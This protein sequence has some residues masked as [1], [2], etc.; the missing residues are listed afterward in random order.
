MPAVG[1]ATRRPLPSVGSPQAGFPYPQ[2]YYGALRRPATVPP[3]FVAFAW[4]YHPVRLCSSLRAGPT[5]AWGQEL[6]VRQLPRRTVARWSPQGLPGSQATLMHLCPVLRP[7]QDRT[8]LAHTACRHG[9]RSDNAEGSPRVMLSGLNSTALVLAV[10]ASPSP[11][12]CRRRK[13]RFR[14]LARPCRVGLATHRVAT[15]GFKDT[16]PSP[17]FLSLA[18]RNVKSGPGP[19]VQSQGG[20]GTGCPSPGDVGFI[21]GTGRRPE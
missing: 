4:R 7:R 20:F 1:S 10:Y 6:W 2:Q 12:R 11:L 19:D 5:P 8:R 13:T 15:K 17:P 21:E 16:R 18:W 3:R 14:W 9:P